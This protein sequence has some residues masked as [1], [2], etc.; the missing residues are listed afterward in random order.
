MVARSLYQSSPAVNADTR[1][2]QA[3]TV[4]MQTQNDLSSKKQDNPI[5]SA[6]VPCRSRH[7]KCDGL[8]PICSRCQTT[9]TNCYY[10]QSRR[11]LRPQKPDSASRTVASQVSFPTER[12]SDADIILGSSYDPGMFSG[13]A[14]DDLSSEFLLGSVPTPIGHTQ[15]S[16]EQALEAGSTL[17]LPNA[18]D[19]PPNELVP[20]VGDRSKSPSIG[21]VAFDPMIQLYYQNFHGSHPFVVPWKAVNSPLCQY[22][23]SYLLSVMRYVGSHYHPNQSFRD[24]YQRKV[25]RESLNDTSRTGFKVQGLLLL[26]IV[27]HSSGYEDRALQTLETAIKMALD[28]RMDRELFV[29]NNSGGNAVL[30]ESWRRTYWELYV[31]SGLFAAFR[32]ET[33]FALHSQYADVRLPCRDEVYNAAGAIPRGVTLEAFQNFWLRGDAS[34]NFSSFSYRI[35]ATQI[36]G[37]ILSLGHH[38]DNNDEIQAEAIDSR[39][40]SIS[41]HLPPAQREIYRSDGV[42]DEMTLQAQMINYL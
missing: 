20:A 31:V 37:T 26:S 18:V 16:L 5:S 23:P 3:T 25:H 6:C 14:M 34:N 21:E 38:M 11:G 10:I 17:N 13:L 36:L 41:M 27:D 9:D 8:A 15:Q 24:I 2:V 7:L 33:T 35:Q 32:Q 30:E 39:L 28:I 1:L 19:L 40:A 42:L 29:L 4:A 12:S 22:L